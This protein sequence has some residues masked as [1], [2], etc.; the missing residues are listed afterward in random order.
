MVAR[1]EKEISSAFLL[2]FL[3]RRD[4]PRLGGEDDSFDHAW[5]D[6]LLSPA[7]AFA[8]AHGA[9]LAASEFGPMRWQPGAA[10]YMLDQIELFEAR[11]MNHALWVWDPSWDFGVGQRG[12]WL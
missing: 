11:R 3:S 5:L 4:G 2:F 10:D 6:S 9:P 12:K 1:Y 7:D 8:A